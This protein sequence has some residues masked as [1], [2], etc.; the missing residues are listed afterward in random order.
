MNGGILPLLLLCAASGLAFA[1]ASPRAGWIGIAAFVA[2]ALIA[3]LIWVPERARNWLFVGLWLSTAASAA[4]TYLPRRP[5]DRWAIALGANNGVWAG[6]TASSLGMQ[7]GLV[8]ALPLIL[9]LI[10]GRWLASRGYAIAIK[11]VASWIIAV[12][13]LAAMVSLAPTPGYAPDHM[14]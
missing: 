5:A 10:P 9:L 1:F 13:A 6:A 12:A 4:S 8:A 7:L 14:E 11:V 2:T 3:G